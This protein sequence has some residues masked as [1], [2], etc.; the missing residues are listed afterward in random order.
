MHTFSIPSPKA[1]FFLVASLVL[2]VHAEQVSPYQ[3]KDRADV[4]LTGR[5]TQASAH[6]FTLDYGKG[7]HHD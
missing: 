7:Q 5:V 6:T 3:L 2:P 4:K 1:F